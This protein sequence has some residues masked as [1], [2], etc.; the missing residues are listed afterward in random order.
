MICYHTTY[1]Y[2]LG[3]QIVEDTFTVLSKILYVQLKSNVVGP[4]SYC[5]VKFWNSLDD[6]LNMCNTVYLFKTVFYIC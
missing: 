5:S 1:I 2:I 6:N 4:I 3:N